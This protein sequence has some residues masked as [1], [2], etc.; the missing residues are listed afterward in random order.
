MTTTPKIHRTATHLA[1]AALAVIAAAP[2][3]FA[4]D[5]RVTAGGTVQLIEGGKTNVSMREEEIEITLRRDHFEVDVSLLFYNSGPRDETHTVGSPIEM[6]G[7]FD[8]SEVERVKSWSALSYT[9]GKTLYDQEIREEYVRTEGGSAILSY[10]RWIVREVV[11]KSESYTESR[12]VYSVPYSQYGGL[13]LATYIYGTGRS[14]NGPIGKMSVIVNH[15]DDIMAGRLAS[16]LYSATGSYNPKP[17]TVA[18]EASGRYRYV[19]KNVAP[20]NKD[21]IL[22]IPVQGFDAPEYGGRDINFG[23]TDGGFFACTLDDCQNYGSWHW[24][25]A[26]LYSGPSDIR[27]FT[28]TQVRLFIN[29]FFAM[30]GYDF[31]NA[32]YKDYF[33]NLKSLDNGK[34]YE[35][36]PQFSEKSFN[37]FERKNIDFLRRMEKMIPAPPG[38]SFT[39][40]RDGRVYRTVKIG[41]QTWMAE[42]LNFKTERSVC[43]DNADSNCTRYGRLY[44]WSDAMEACPAG[45][46]LSLNMDWY[47][48]LDYIRSTYWASSDT[49][50]PRWG[51]KA[52]TLK[53]RYLWN[54][55]DD[56]D[57]NDGDWTREC[58]GNG[59]DVH[60]FS[61][62]PGGMRRDG[63]F[64]DRGMLGLWWSAAAEYEH[65]YLNRSYYWVIIAD[66]DNIYEG[67]WN[68]ADGFSVRCVKK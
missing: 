37:D 23:C 63:R 5:A 49:E 40:A 56:D 65:R 2:G 68:I 27:M 21:A 31:K 50:G 53:S 47:Y 1:L 10:K 62:L 11:F 32:Y 54:R 38:P 41:K 43:Y 67:D 61:A 8:D 46:R 60:G 25:K 44:D 22:E 51:G 35:V 4:N 66:S 24:D 26:L 30:H 34:K 59:D 52:E 33:Q 16:R 15:G 18:W 20:Q 64:I 12:V 48:L 45:W 55:C 29:H 28:K 6:R 58:D 7:L 3:A 17:D 57:D 19:F 14:W 36:N 39:D 42:N 13:K 9:N